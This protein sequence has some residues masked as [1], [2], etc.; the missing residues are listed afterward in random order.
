[1]GPWIEGCVPDSIMYVPGLRG[2]VREPKVSAVVVPAATSVEN[3]CTRGPCA[4]GV[5]LVPGSAIGHGTDCALLWSG[6]DVEVAVVPRPP[7]NSPTITSEVGIFPPAHER[8]FVRLIV[9]ACPVVM[10][11]SYDADHQTARDA[12]V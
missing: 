3:D 2:F 7:P 6:L 8:L 10:V 11:L 9:S 1:M 5:P 12:G 4:G